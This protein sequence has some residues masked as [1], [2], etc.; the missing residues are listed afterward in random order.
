M[1]RQRRRLGW[2]DLHHTQS[3]ILQKR[4]KERHEQSGDDCFVWILVNLFLMLSDIGK[5]VCFF[6]I[7]FYQV[8][9]SHHDL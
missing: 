9:L 1:R 2:N 6:V 7:Y 4:R 3:W 8:W 5:I